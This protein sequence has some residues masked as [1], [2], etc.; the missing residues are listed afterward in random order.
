MD[1]YIK[2]ARVY[3]SLL[4]AFIPWVIIVWC[5]WDVL[6]KVQ[7]CMTMV[8]SYLGIVSSTAGCFAVLAYALRETFR[9]TSKWLFQFPFFKEDETEM[10]TTEMLLWSKNQMS[11]Q[12][13]KNIIAKVKRKFNI[14]LPSETK[15]AEDEQEA[16]RTIVNAVA[17]MRAVTRDN[18]ILLQYNYEFGFC[19]NYLGSAVYD[20][21]FMV[22]AFIVNHYLQLMPM[23]GLWIALL[24]MLI[25]YVIAFISLKYRARAYADNLFTAF[26]SLE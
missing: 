16:R 12:R 26:L 3:P 18:K 21:T 10:P 19:R 24:V 25:S 22:I 17:Q 23:W 4:A 11:K 1:K 2:V 15:E 7:E 14:Q 8:F 20:L 13:H 5:L 9:S 6:P